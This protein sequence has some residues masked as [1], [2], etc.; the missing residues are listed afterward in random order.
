MIEHKDK[1]PVSQSLKEQHWRE[2][3]HSNERM[4]YVTC[5]RGMF[6]EI[7]YLELENSDFNL[8]LDWYIRGEAEWN[9]PSEEFPKN[10]PIDSLKELGLWRVDRFLEQPEEVDLPLAI[11]DKCRTN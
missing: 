11:R 4:T 7:S 6:V 9:G 5:Y 3:N 10:F 8:T 2:I 1:I